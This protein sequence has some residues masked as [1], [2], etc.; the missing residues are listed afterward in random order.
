MP[1]SSWGIS[2]W[3]LAENSIRDP[4]Y[5]ESLTCLVFNGYLSIPYIILVERHVWFT[6]ITMTVMQCSMQPNLWDF[7]DSLLGSPGR[8][9]LDVGDVRD[10]R[11]VRDVGDHAGMSGTS[12]T[13]G[14]SG[15]SD[16]EGL[17]GDVRPR[18]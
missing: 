15:T 4:K 14:T 10:V 7:E 12:E 11:D 18:T 13:S 16:R 9:T 6:K 2:S 1:V 8:W 17:D 3:G 5:G